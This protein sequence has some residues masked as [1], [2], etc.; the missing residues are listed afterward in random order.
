MA[1]PMRPRSR[2]QEE[3]WSVRSTILQSAVVGAVTTTTVPN[4][5]IR[6]FQLVEKFAKSMV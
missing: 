6:R 3:Q 1:S 2:V 5:A 4:L